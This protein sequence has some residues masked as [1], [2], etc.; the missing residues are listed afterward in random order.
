MDASARR[1]AETYA[2]K[3]LRPDALRAWKRWQA[4][5]ARLIIVTASPESVVAPFAR[6]LGC[7]PADRHPAGV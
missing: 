2:R 1:Y 6:G 4:Q 3:L 7:R 5:G